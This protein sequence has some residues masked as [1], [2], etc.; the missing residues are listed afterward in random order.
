[1]ATENTTS[2]LVGNFKEIYGT[3]VKELAPNTLKLSRRINYTYA[4][5]LGNKYHQPVDLSMEH[6]VTYAAANASSIT[7]L[8]PVAG[9][10]QDAQVEGAQV[11]A[12]SRVD[13]ES[14]YRANQAGK[15]AFVES[16][17]HV[18]R[19][20]T[21]AASKRLEISTLHGRR[22][23]GTLGS[24]SGSSTTRTWVITDASWSAGIWAG[25]KNMTLDAFAANYTGSKVNS[26][27]KVTITSVDIANKTLSVSGNATDLTAIVAGMHLFPETASPTNEFAG[28]DAIVR[29]TGSLFGISASDYEL[30]KGHTISSVGRLTMTAILNGV[31]RGVEL[32]LEDDVLCVVSPRAFEVLNDDLAALRKLDSSYEVNEGVN[33]VENIKYHG[34]SGTVEV[35]PHLFQKDGQAHIINPKEWKRIGATDLTFI[36]RGANGEE[37][38]V[39]EMANSPSSEMRCYFNGAMFCEAPA[40]SV[41]LDGITYS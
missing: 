6:G 12:R 41:C 30:W 4:E 35:M 38:L 1:M 7:L 24:V 33:G 3:D 9:Q 16:T 25:S 23:I 36:T 15:K 11:F 29:N 5:A 21:R 28:I 32:G 26:N 13:Y 37:K 10:M 40:H 14:I 20:L 22:G 27:A 34:Q 2:T 31:S 39:L 8:D 17:Q 18:V 19:R